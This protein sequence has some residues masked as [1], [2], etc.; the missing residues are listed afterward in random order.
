[1]PSSKYKLRSEEV[2]EVM[3]KPPHALITWGNTLVLTILVVGMYLLS[4]IQFPDKLRVPFQLNISEKGLL[5]LVNVELPRQ[6]KSNQVVLLAFE[7]YPSENYGKVRSEIDS[8]T[9]QQ[10]RVLIALKN[11]KASTQT[12]TNKQI[13]LH[14]H[15]LGTAEIIVG[16]QNI[17][18]MLKKQLVG[19]SHL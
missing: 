7:S 12:N 13:T 3:S 2:Q 10:G 5:C 11:F 6:I 16:Q 1:M 19:M 4:L 15:Q 14:N 9:N 18:T 17:F 8:I